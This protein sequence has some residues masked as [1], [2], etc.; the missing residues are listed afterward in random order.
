MLIIDFDNKISMFAVGKCG[1]TALA[2]NL[3]SLTTEEPGSFFRA[4]RLKFISKN[5]VPSNF[6]QLIDEPEFFYSIPVAHSYLMFRDLFKIE[7]FTHYVFVRKPVSRVISGLETLVNW[8]MPELWKAFQNGEATIN[9]LWQSAKQ[10]EEYDYHIKEF[11]HVIRNLDC[12]YLNMEDIN[13]FIKK[14]YNFDAEHV[15]SMPFW[16]KGIDVENVSFTEFTE[17]ENPAMWN[18]ITLEVN[19]FRLQCAMDYKDVISND[20][21][22]KEDKLYK[23]LDIT[24]IL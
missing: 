1:S 2:Y 18:H 24:T 22:T 12:V 9:D 23:D 8:W 3:Q 4:N 11:L 14:Y 13:P 10:H 21:F 19:K 7:G 17:K 15:P 16:T 20:K 5:P 6:Q